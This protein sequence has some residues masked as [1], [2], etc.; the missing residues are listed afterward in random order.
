MVEPRVRRYTDANEFQRLNAEDR[1]Q[2]Q[3]G[4][5]YV[6]YH[7]HVPPLDELIA[8][9]V[10]QHETP[11]TERIARSVIGELAQCGIDEDAA[12]RYFAY[13]YQLRRAFHFIVRSLTG[14]S[15]PMRQLRRALCDNVFT[16]DM[17]AYSESLWNRM[18]DFSTLL[19][20]ETGGRR[21]PAHSAMPKAPT[22]RKAIFDATSSRLATPSRKRWSA[23]SWYD[24]C[25]AIGWRHMTPAN[26][27]SSRITSTSER[28]C[29][30]RRLKAR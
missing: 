21:C 15:E 30:I 7:R 26:S 3:K 9:E 17:R 16:H 10:A 4:F 27:A 11:P 2:V 8:R 14:A 18:E 23:K 20:G 19:L 12:T 25:C 24:A 13:F 5:L 29:R 1:R 28:Q 22:I 6:C